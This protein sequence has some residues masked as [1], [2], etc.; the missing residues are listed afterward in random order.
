MTTAY[1]LADTENWPLIQ[2]DG[3]LCANELIARAGLDSSRTYRD[4]NVQL[5]TGA[6]I[7]DQRPMPPAALA[8]CLDP[9]LDPE[10]WYALVNSKVFF[11][12]SRERLERHRAACRARPQIVLAIDLPAL[13]A[14]HGARA[15]V[16]PFNVGNARRNAASR[17]HR[18]FVPIESWRT[19]RWEPEARAGHPTR[20]RSH[21]P[22]ELAIDHA[23]PDIMDFIITSRET[24]APDTSK[25]VTAP[26]LTLP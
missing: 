13:L 26:A 2:R 1:H 18:T 11:W 6:W 10:D 9:G 17:G 21:P 22:A 16:T 20:P 15:Y 12:L 23:V 8:R 5:P 4:H 14:R 7:R 25:T 19:T 24:F 3:L